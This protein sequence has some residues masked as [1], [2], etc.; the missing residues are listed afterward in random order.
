MY[1]S[2]SE[3]IFRSES[4]SHYGSI[5]KDPVNEGSNWAAYMNIV[6]VLAGSGTLGI[7]Y[8]IQLGGWISVPILIIS[9]TMTYYANTKLIECLHY[10]EQNSKRKTSMSDLAYEAYGNAGFFVIGF[11][12]NALCI[13][14]P[15]LFL[16][17]A[18]HN[19]QELF[20]NI[21]I[22]LGIRT[23]IY[24]CASIM[25]IP[26]ILLRSMKEAAFLSAVGTITTAFVVIVISITSIVEYPNNRDKRHEFIN[27][28]NIPLSMATFS[29]SYGGNF[30]FPQIEASL[31]NPKKWP[32]ILRFA[33]FSVTIM[34]L[35]IGIPAYLTYGETLRS[36]V[37]I[38]L[39]PGFSITISIIMI[40]IHVL[41]ALPVYQTVFSVEIEN[42]LGFDTKNLSKIRQHILRIL[43]RII[44]MIFTVYIAVNV[45]YFSD[46]MQLFGATGNGVLSVIMPIL[47]WIK[48]IGWEKLNGFKDKCWV[49]FTL[50]FSLC[51]TIIGTIDALNILWIDITE[52]L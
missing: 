4:Y 11:F 28:R 18:G 9:A 47:F 37:Y 25:C 5:S 13:G 40:T 48:L 21:G 38:G 42:Y 7:P 8:A 33:I 20:T 29:F 6:C 46:L 14:C 2:K 51:A 10:D 3:A 19:L 36:P 39:Q 26:F 50:T 31:K 1:K 22:D 32:E 12:F 16:I 35:I 43:L 24:I 27:F 52:K 44:I 41:L 23:W 45:P 15:I 17:L 49:I 34:Y 30:I